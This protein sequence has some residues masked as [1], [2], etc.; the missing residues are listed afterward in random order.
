[1]KNCKELEKE[2]ELIIFILDKLWWAILALG[3]GLG[4]LLLKKSSFSLMLFTTT[5]F[6]F[7][8]ISWII[9]L[10]QIRKLIKKFNICKEDKNET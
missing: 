2:F 3:G 6:W 10:F 5:L 9:G 8:L 1:M 4:T 7:L